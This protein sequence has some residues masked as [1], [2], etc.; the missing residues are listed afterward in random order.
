M[1]L[2]SNYVLLGVEFFK[3]TIT[4]CARKIKLKSN[5]I[6]LQLQL[7]K[8]TMIYRLYI[9]WAIIQSQIQ[10]GSTWISTIQANDHLYTVHVVCN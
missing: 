6:L 4:L 8:Q 5:W 2:K 9:L 7:S 10:L 1:Q 3:Q